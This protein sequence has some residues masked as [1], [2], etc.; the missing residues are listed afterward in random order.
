MMANIEQIFDLDNDTTSTPQ[1]R[2]RTDSHSK[3]KTRSSKKRSLAEKWQRLVAA[4][5][6]QYNK[7]TR[8]NKPIGSIHETDGNHTISS[9]NASKYENKNQLS[10]R[11]ENN[12]YSKP[13]PKVN[14]NNKKGMDKDDRYKGLSPIEIW[15]KKKEERE[16]LKS[17]QSQKQTE[18]KETDDNLKDIN[19]Q[20]L[21]EQRQIIKQKEEEIRKEREA[22]AEGQR[23]KM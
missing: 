14:N 12:G 10:S 3:G 17:Q 6:K 4:N 19:Q 21:N 23:Q 8:V 5:A 20:K 13:K 15:K 22:E 18:T 2:Q 7:P 11:S 9:F 1:T 16:R